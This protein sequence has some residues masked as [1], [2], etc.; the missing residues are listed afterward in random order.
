METLSC[1]QVQKNVG[2][3]GA[4]SLNPNT[5]KLLWRGESH[6]GFTPKASW[7]GMLSH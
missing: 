3:C 6:T 5:G 2:Q 4:Y 7:A 1:T